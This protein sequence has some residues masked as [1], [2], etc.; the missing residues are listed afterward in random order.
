MNY[1]RDLVQGTDSPPDRIVDIATLWEPIKCLCV[2]HKRL[3]IGAGSQLIAIDVE[4]LLD[5][6][7]TS[8]ESAELG[9]LGLG[10]K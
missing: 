2:A 3:Y 10:E 6:F 9:C 1:Y 4:D 5:D 8:T 7:Q